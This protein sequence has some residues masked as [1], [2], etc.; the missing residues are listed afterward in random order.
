MIEN[1]ITLYIVRSHGHMQYF[2]WEISYSFLAQ[3]TSHEWNVHDWSHFDTRGIGR[4]EI[5]GGGEASNN[6]VGIICPPLLR[7]GYWSSK[8][9]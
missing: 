4:S 7:L 6:V 9:F 3:F 5:Q 2:S 1:I 8:I